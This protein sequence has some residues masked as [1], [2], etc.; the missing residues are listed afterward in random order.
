M[1]WALRGCRMC[2]LSCAKLCQSPACY[3]RA[4]R[5]RG[6]AR[7]R[8]LPRISPCSSRMSCCLRAADAA[9]RHRRWPA[10]QVA[11]TRAVR[12]PAWAVVADPMPARTAVRRARPVREPTARA[13]PRLSTQTARTKPPQAVPQVGALRA[14]EVKLAVRAEPHQVAPPAAGACPVPRRAAAPEAQAFPQSWPRLQ[15]IAPHR[16]PARRPR[17][18]SRQPAA[19]MR[20][21]VAE[22]AATAPSYARTMSA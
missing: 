2:R 11:E 19:L 20:T 13:A 14:V 6:C 8:R 4:A 9:T 21:A 18:F 15:R 7:A 3:A 17:T 10:R 1:A 16:S 12:T 5:C 22:A